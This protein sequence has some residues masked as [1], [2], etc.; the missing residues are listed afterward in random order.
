MWTENLNKFKLF[1]SSSKAD[2]I[3]HCLN[4][5]KFF[6]FYFVDIKVTKFQSKFEKFLAHF[7]YIYFILKMIACL[8]ILIG[9][10]ATLYSFTPRQHFMEIAL[11]CQFSGS[12][13]LTFLMDYYYRATDRKFWIIFHQTENLNSVFLKIPR[14][15]R[16]FLIFKLLLLW[17]LTLFLLYNAI[18]FKSASALLFQN[19]G[20]NAQYVRFLLYHIQICWLKFIFYVQVLIYQL[21]MLLS[22]G[23]LSEE[24]FLVYQRILTNIW[25][26]SVQIEKIFGVQMVLFISII[27]FMLIFVQ[28]FFLLNMTNE[29][30]IIIPIFFFVILIT[31]VAI[32]S[33]HCWV[34][35]FKVT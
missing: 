14:K 21:D 33:M 31:G 16:I 5:F 11:F 23:D 22:Y 27:L 2:N 26:M 9:F 20:G 32:V 17:T 25:K 3:A 15:S 30:S 1:F 13:I 34:C 29:E 10:T 8:R 4:I 19:F 18:R 7:A 6:G 24:N 35:V 28:Y 12:S